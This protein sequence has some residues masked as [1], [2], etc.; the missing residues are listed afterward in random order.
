MAKLTRREFTGLM[1]SSMAPLWGQDQLVHIGGTWNF[2]KAKSSS[3]R[4]ALPDLF[5]LVIIQTDVAVSM[6]ETVRWRDGSPETIS[7]TY[8]ADGKD[9]TNKFPD[10]TV[11]HGSLTI[12]SSDVSITWTA[13]N[14]GETQSGTSLLAPGIDGSLSYVTTAKDAEGPYRMTFVFDQG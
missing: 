13:S 11:Q 8:T 14:G 2:N 3:D 10:G 7:L 6:D 1:I 9:S 5:T 12:G 4:F